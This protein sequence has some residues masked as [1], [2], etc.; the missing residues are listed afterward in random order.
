MRLL[1]AGFQYLV[2]IDHTVDEMDDLEVVIGKI[3]L[4]QISHHI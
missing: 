2:E 4:V 3:D 1:A